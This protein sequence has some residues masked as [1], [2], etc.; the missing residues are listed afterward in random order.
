MSE[1][2]FGHDPGTSERD[3]TLIA[4]YVRTART[5]D[6]LPYTSEFDE[7]R[8]AL[9]TDDSARDVLHRLMNLRKAGKLPRLGKAPTLAVK[10][11]PEEEATLVDLLRGA[12]GTTGARDRLPYTDAFDALHA[13]FNARIGRELDR[14]TT[15]RLICKLAK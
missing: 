4:V 9:G 12:L 1:S 3:E 7:L 13:E 14:H 6:D 15:W 11:T 10:L 2:L 8:G 5:L